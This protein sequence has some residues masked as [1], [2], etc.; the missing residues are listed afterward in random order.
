MTETGSES[1]RPAAGAGESALPPPAAPVAAQISAET[2][3]DPARVEAEQR[4][5][6]ADLRESTLRFEREDA[7]RKHTLALRIFWWGGGFAALVAA[8]CLAFAFVG[9]E[10]QSAYAKE[11]LRSLGIA[12][13]GGGVIQLVVQALR[14]LF[15]R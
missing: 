12:L 6:E 1:P 7:A 11:L 9:P 8:V 13:A 3:A 14:W 4:K 5:R 2:A 15:A 10:P